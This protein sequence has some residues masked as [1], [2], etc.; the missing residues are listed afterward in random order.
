MYILTDGKRKYAAVKRGDVY[1]INDLGVVKNLDVGKTK[2]GL[3]EFLVLPANLNDYMSTLRRKAQI[4]VLKDAAYIIAR[5]GIRA[6]S[7]VVEGGAGSGSL[8]TALLYFTYPSGK[9]YTYEMREDFA[10]IA[11]EN[12]SRGEFSKNW[13]LKIGDVRK[14]VIERD[15]DAFIL[16]IPDPWNAVD[17]AREALRVSGCFAAYV[18]TYNQVEK[19]Y[20]ALEKNFVDL[21]A[22][23]IIKRELVV[24]ELGTRPDNVEVAHTG[25]MVFGRKI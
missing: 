20:R 12:V 2:L 10:N 4:I 24:G 22:C 16:D 14:D 7:V 21:E 6:G 11:R 8:T 25:F 1:R 23:E 5:C 9:V 3:R 15:V 18:P 13:V 19:V 17:M